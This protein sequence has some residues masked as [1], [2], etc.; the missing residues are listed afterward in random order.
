MMNR[1]RF[2]TFLGAGMV[3]AAA[4]LSIGMGRAFAAESSFQRVKNSGV[5]RIGGVPDGAPITRRA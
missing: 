4:G 1:R 5:L 3:S 2:N